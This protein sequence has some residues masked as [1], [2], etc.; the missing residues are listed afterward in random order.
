MITPVC[1]AIGV[2]AVISTGVSI[3]QLP[4][5]SIQQLPGV[6]IQQ[7]PGVSIQQLPGVSIQQLPGVSIDYQ[8]LLQLSI[9]LLFFSQGDMEKARGIQPHE[10]YDRDKAHIPAVQIS[11]LDHVSTS[12]P[13]PLRSKV[14]MTICNLHKTRTASHLQAVQ[15]LRNKRHWERLSELIRVKRGGSTSCMTF[16]EVLA[17]EQEEIDT[18]HVVLNHA[19]TNGEQS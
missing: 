9:M 11:F 4:G 17:M 19:L 15:Y 18:D 8:S 13:A 5:L 1:N 6:S 16:E 12:D 2:Q 7:L 14:K 10:M 3:Q